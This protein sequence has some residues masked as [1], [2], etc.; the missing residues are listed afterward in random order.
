MKNKRFHILI[1][2]LFLCLAFALAHNV[3]Q[4]EQSPFYRIIA[5]A[6]RAIVEG[7]YPILADGRTGERLVITYS[8]DKVNELKHA[9]AS[10]KGGGWCNGSIK[11][12]NETSFYCG[13][14]FLGRMNCG[15]NSFVPWGIGKSAEFSANGLASLIDGPLAELAKIRTKPPG[16]NEREEN[17]VQPLGPGAN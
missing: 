11:L 12:F 6:D 8:G 4:P 5:K 3:R 2:L 10:A 13:T 15:G 7:G 9:I 16:S 1:T 17:T 14:N